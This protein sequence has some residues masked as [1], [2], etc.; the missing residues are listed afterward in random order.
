MSVLV[1]QHEKTESSGRLG[2][3]LQS[4]GHRLRTIGLYAG[5]SVPVD[6]DNVDGIISM[7]G[8]PNVDQAD[9]YP[10]MKPEMEYL[11]AAHDAGVPIVGVC[12]G[13]QL[14]AAALGGEVKPM[15]SPEVG[16]HNVKLSFPGTIDPLY[17]GIP[18]DTVQFHLHGQEVTK[19]PP[20]GTPLAGSKACKI[21]AFKVGLTTYAFQYHFEWDQKTINE[22]VQNGLV[23]QA[24][25]SP[26]QIIDQNAQ[27]Y[28]GFARLGERLCENIATLLMPVDKR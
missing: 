23:K 14:V 12:L 6:L 20:G 11:K 22:V 7:G 10:W 21:Q 28:D 27:H 19:L 17:A 4:Q 15:A 13:A 25:V 3:A 1:F 26:Q 8:T 16:W 5:E 18:W 2:W 9:Q 24:G